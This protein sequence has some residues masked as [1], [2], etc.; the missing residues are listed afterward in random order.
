[1]KIGHIF[2]I[3][4]LTI[5]FIPMIAD[6]SIPVN[7]LDEIV[8]TGSKAWIS[9]GIVNVRPSKRDKRLSNSPVTLIENMHIPF[10]KVKD[11]IVVSMSGEPIDLFINGEKVDNIDLATFWPSDVILV[12][13]IDNPRNP[14]YEGAKKVVDFKMSVYKLGGVSKIDAFQRFPNNGIYTASSKLGYKRMIYG[15]MVS[16]NYF[17]DHRTFLNGETDYSDIYYDNKHYDFISRMEET[18]CFSRDQGVR[19]A[20]NVRFSTSRMRIAHNVSLGWMEN[21]GSG[22]KSFDQWSENIFVSDYSSSFNTSRNIT[23]QIKGN[24]YFQL[25]DKWFLSAA[26]HYSYAH[27]NSFAS[28]VFGGGSPVDNYVKEDV[29]TLKVSLMPSFWLSDKWKF[30]LPMKTEISWF[31]T[32]YTGLT[33]IRHKQTRQDMSGSLNVFWQPMNTVSL[34]VA[35]GV[36]GSLWQIDGQRYTSISPVA[37]ASVSWN[38]SSVFNLNGSLRFYMRP[39][40]TTESNTVLLKYS[41][42]LWIQGNPRLKGLKSWDT[43]IYSTYL[44]KSWLSLSFGLGY[45]RTLDDLITYYTVA[46]IEQGGLIKHSI[47]AKASDRIRTNLEIGG[48]FFDENLTVSVSPQWH[49][50]NSGNKNNRHFNHFSLSGEI[51]YSLGNCE[52]ELSYDGPYKD[53]SSEGMERSW[54]RDCWNF[55]FTY[56]N[57]NWY[58]EFGIDNIFNKKNKSWTQYTSPHYSTIFNSLET[59]RSLSVK[60]SYT[61]G[62]GKKLDK[63]IDISGPDNTSTTVYKAER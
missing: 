43:Y 63:N 37:D 40:S 55:A 57:G 8:V 4:L 41:D 6:D 14:V 26:A 39:P 47:N 9:D 48:S 20:F 38:P 53:L 30:Q 46:P 60:L 45:V 19:C 54:Q 58:F 34:S 5:S 33:Q 28:T 50:V 25:T 61:L 16:G 35:P 7:E 52:F 42:L 21:P 29:N 32:Q 59:G 23:P 24:Y 12:Q 56:G 27:N 15:V 22:S 3:T 31:T 10:L 49:Y 17:R 1:M 2:L 13:Y 62:Y 11:G 18:S 36:I 44:P 51:G